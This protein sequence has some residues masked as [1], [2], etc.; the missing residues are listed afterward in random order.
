MA[1]PSPCTPATDDRARSS[2]NLPPSPLATPA[3]I[4]ALNRASS[5]PCRPF[6][7]HRERALRLVAM[8]PRFRIDRYRGRSGTGMLCATPP[9]ADPRRNRVASD[10]ASSGSRSPTHTS[11]PG[12]LDR[13]L[14]RAICRSD[15]RSPVAASDS[16]VPS[17]DSPVGMRCPTQ[18]AS[19]DALA[20][21]TCRRASPR[22]SRCGNGALRLE[23]PPLRTMGAARHPPAARPPRQDAVAER[24]SSHWKRICGRGGRKVRH[25]GT[26]RP[27]AIRFAPCRSVPFSDARVIS[28]VKPVAFAASCTAPPRTNHPRCA[29][30]TEPPCTSTGTPAAIRNTPAPALPLFRKPTHAIRAQALVALGERSSAGSSSERSPPSASRISPALAATTVA[31]YWR[32]DTLTRPARSGT[33]QASVARHR[34][35][36]RHPRS[37]ADRDT[38]RRVSSRLRAPRPRDDSPGL[39]STRSGAATA[40][41]ARDARARLRAAV[42][43]PVARARS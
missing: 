2:K 39:P 34:S 37:A 43:L 27:P 20:N 32:G 30:R 24:K 23:Q 31:A 8:I 5:S 10:A 6:E 33:A 25:Q 38:P 17:T 29:K 36:A 21:D 7:Q 18:P 35:G 13:D 11:T 41:R 15:G 1:P 19:R 12:R 42:T 22:D 16:S 28:D 40:P 14:L 26:R 9:H 4:P 3:I